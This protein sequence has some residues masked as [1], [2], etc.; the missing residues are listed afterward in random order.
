MKVLLFFFATAIF[1]GTGTRH[2]NP[3]KSPEPG[4]TLRVKFVPF[5]ISDDAKIKA[6][7]LLRMNNEA[8]DGEKYYGAHIRYDKNAGVKILNVYGEVTGGATYNPF[9]VSYIV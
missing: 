2:H 5:D 7:I 9:A 8:V 3:L 1:L 6:E 4:D